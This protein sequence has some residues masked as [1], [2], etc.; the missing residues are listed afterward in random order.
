MRRARRLL[1]TP[2]AIGAIVYACVFPGFPAYLFY[3]G[4]VELI[5]AARAGQF[6]HLMPVFGVL[7]AMLFLGEALHPYHAAGIGADCRWAVAG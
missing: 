5:G 7:L 4:G 3:N 1:P 6:L 2:L